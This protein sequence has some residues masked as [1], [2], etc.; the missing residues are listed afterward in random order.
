[1]LCCISHGLSFPAV[2]VTSC[3]HDILALRLPLHDPVHLNEE[4]RSLPMIAYRTLKG[5]V[6]YTYPEGTFLSSVTDDGYGVDPTSHLQGDS[7]DL[8]S[9]VQL[10]VPL[11][12][13]LE[14]LVR[15]RVGKS[16]CAVSHCHRKCGT[17]IKLE[18][19][20]D[21]ETIDVRFKGLQQH[22][23][24][25]SQK[26]TVDKRLHEYDYKEKICTT[27]HTQDPQCPTM[28]TLT[29]EIIMGVKN[30]STGVK[31]L[32]RV[33]TLNGM[34]ILTR[35]KSLSM[36]VKT[37]RVTNLNG[38][39]IL[40][41]AKSLS[42]GV[43]T[44]TRVITLSGV[45]TPT[46]TLM[47]TQTPRNPQTMKMKDLTKPAFMETK[48]LMK[49]QKPTKFKTLMKTQKPTKFQTL[50]KT[51]KPTKFQTLMKTQKPTKF[52]T[53]MKTTKHQ[54]PPSLQMLIKPWIPTK[55]MK[56]RMS[57][58]TLA[59][60]MTLAVTMA[61]AVTITLAIV[62]APAPGLGVIM[63]NHHIINSA[64]S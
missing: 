58:K 49:T 36:R 43:K 21:D 10:I 63:D 40:T 46:K 50:M 23:V 22:G 42:T 57:T 47:K 27:H 11:T 30:L 62:L 55:P 33:T 54:K 28:N 4:T 53:L 37:L 19:G 52:Q 18:W 45:K 20:R 31:T 59:V 24:L 6:K 17:T 38:M 48:T 2:W 44:L 61:L 5:D 7:V 26:E 32:T 12:I 1:M 35:A 8:I 41:G 15:Y 16:L 60:M 14:G 34:K 9:P 39:K 64:P 3:V 56:P 25:R 29:G 51:Q 13:Y